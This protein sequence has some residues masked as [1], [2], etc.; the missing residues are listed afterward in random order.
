MAGIRT[1]LG[2]YPKTKDYEQKRNKL[3]DEYKTLIEFENSE[4]LVKFKELDQFLK[5][6]DYRS[7]KKEL[8]S[9][10][11]KNSEDFKKE[12]AFKKLKKDKSLKLYFKVLAG[13][14]LQQIQKL[15][16][17][18]KLK[19]FGELQQLVESAAFK[20]KKS[21]GGNAFKESDEY[22]K[23][24]EYSNLKNDSEIKSYISFSSSK[25]YKNYLT[26]KDSDLLKR[27][28]ALKLFV[29]SKEFS[30]R[31]AYLTLSPKL[32]WKQSEA[33]KKEA[34]YNSLKK[35]SRLKSYFKNKGN[36]KFAWFNA[37]EKTFEDT[38]ATGK[39]DR[40]K[41]LTRYY[42]GDEMIQDSYS[43]TDEKHGI[44]DGDN[45]DISQGILRIH[46]KKE[47]T[48]GKIWNTENGFIPREFDYSSGLINTGKSFRQ[49]FGLFE[50]KLKVSS[51]P[52][53]MNAFWMVGNQMLPHIDVFKAYK[54]CTLGLKT[55]NS[56]SQKELKKS[57]YAAEFHVV[58]MEWDSSKIVWKINGQEINRITNNIPQEEMYLAFSSGLY[59]DISAGLPAS[60]Q[61]EWVKC[62]QSR[63]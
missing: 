51:N 18:A 15:N 20:S 50:A 23:F 48:Q 17:S 35:S 46:T 55:M 28:D 3:E 27:Y 12:Q 40:E 38:F 8:L 16:D 43:L 61:I 42:W 26:V 30:D 4:E 34:E 24:Q 7:V 58:S 36:K 37:W 29:E 33:G 11:Y 6:E 63:N 32:R 21:A 10:K 31:K 39:L 57:K 56:D 22:A 62:Y 5:S 45:I 53:L 1:I 2:L 52:D 41:W 47:K 9:L 19:K 59:D 49:K 54:T 44:T 14:G 13:S 60:M 25:E